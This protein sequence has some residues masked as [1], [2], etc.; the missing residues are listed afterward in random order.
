MSKFYLCG[1][2][3]REVDQTQVN[4]KRGPHGTVDFLTQ[5]IPQLTEAGVAIQP[6][7]W[8]WLEH[9]QNVKSL[10]GSFF[11][12]DGASLDRFEKT[13]G[14]H[15][16]FAKRWLIFRYH[17]AHQQQFNRLS[18]RHVLNANVLFGTHDVVTA[19]L[20]QRFSKFDIPIVTCPYGVAEWWEYP[21]P[22]ANP[23]EPGTTNLVFAGRLEQGNK[24]DRGRL[25]I[26]REIYRRDPSIKLH[27]ITQSVK[28]GKLNPAHL[29]PNCVCHGEMQSGTFNHFL[30]YADLGLD[31][32]TARNATWLNCKH[33]AYIGMGLPVVAHQTPGTEPAEE[34]RCG[35]ILK[36]HDIPTFVDA[37]FAALDVEWP[38]RD[39]VIREA[40]ERYG[41]RKA[42]DVL[43]KYIRLGEE[44]G[45]HSRD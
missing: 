41:W 28:H 42:V 22:Q 11:E 2:W 12:R 13:V 33:Y 21:P 38:D 31:T 4:R 27:I 19:Q 36:E 23:Y 45:Y 26:F 14:D 6:N 18:G 44:Q 7:K 29:P 24:L 32:T 17:A 3:H 43:E 16:D 20:K 25:P 8:T 1:A 39:L 9:E 37:V 40:Q 30:Y 34:L 35:I 15:F 10:W 5:A